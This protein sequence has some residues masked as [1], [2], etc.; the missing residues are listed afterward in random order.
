M[1]GN[2]INFHD[3]SPFLFILNLDEI[4]YNKSKRWVR[5]EG[6]RKRKKAFMLIWAAL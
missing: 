3:G 5:Y 2:A 1:I 6:G 4:M